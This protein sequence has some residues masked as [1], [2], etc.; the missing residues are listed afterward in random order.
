MKIYTRT[1][2]DGETG[3]FGGTRVPKDAL[4]IESYGTIDELNAHLG[5]VRSL[6]P[7]NDIDDELLL[8]QNELFVLGADLATPSEKTGSS[9]RRILPS[10]AARLE[11]VIDRIDPLLEPLRAFI[12]PGG[13]PVA[14]QLHVAR[15]ICRRAERLIVRLAHAEPPLR[16]PIIYLNRLS[17]LLFI[18]ARYAN[19]LS[20]TSE[21]LWQS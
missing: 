12:L 3:L 19:H 9:I 21:M 1:G 11:R 4:R 20:G 18:L 14:A 17:D 7:P 16:D 8:I 2:D 15:T 5:V 10:D 13:T 6:L